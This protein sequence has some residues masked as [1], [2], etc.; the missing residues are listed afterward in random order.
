MTNILL[1]IETINR[2]IDYKLV[3]AAQLA[4]KE[5]HI[6]IGQHD[7]L[8]DLLPQLNGGI[9]LGKNIFKKRADRENGD[10]YKRLK[11]HNFN[12]IY[13]HEEG[14]VFAGKENDWKQTLARQYNIDFFDEND[15]ICT[16]G[17]FQ[18]KYDESRA[19]SKVPVITTGHPRFD[20]YKKDW[21]FLFEK[22][23]IDLKEKYGNFVLING[24][25]GLANH[26]KGLNHVFS[27][28]GNYNVDDDINRLNRIGFFTHTTKQMISMVELTHQLAVKFP[29]TIFIYRPHPSENHEYYNIIF[30]GVENII[31]NHTGSVNAWILASDA[32]IHDGCTTAIEAS[33][34]G[35]KV[36]NFKAT[37]DSEYDIWLPKQMGIKAENLEAV[38]NCLKNRQEDKVISDNKISELMYNFKGDSF[39]ALNEILVNSLKEV[40]ETQSKNKLT[41]NYIVNLYLKKKAKENFISLHPQKRKSLKY[42]Q[43]K[44]KGFSEENINHKHK[45]LQKEFNKVIFLKI[46]NKYL[47]EIK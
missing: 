19:S 23:I 45:L 30:K 13:L 35:K 12:I 46:H 38:I 20:L 15:V 10:I 26:G 11:K 25:F 32:I 41:S 33:L 18:K 43:T 24:N 1:P 31:V 6:Y 47:I 27:N 4:N 39:K 9:Y 29:K 40:E 21:Q 34:A 14:A 36:I 28:A 2:E 3:L 7:F 44:F 37:A 16:W 42:H 17:D 22:E 5:H 8:M